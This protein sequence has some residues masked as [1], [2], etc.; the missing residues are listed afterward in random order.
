M[1]FIPNG[2][3]IPDELLMARDAGN[4]LFF[5]GAGVSRAEAKLPDFNT[6]AQMVMDRLGATKSSPARQVFAATE[7][8][9]EEIRNSNAGGLVAAD[10]L[11][12]L[13][14][15][16]FDA[17]DVRQAVAQSL[18][19]ATG[20]SLAPHRTLLELS[21]GGTGTPRLVTTNFDLLFEQCDAELPNFSPPNL[22]DPR[23]DQDFKGIIHLHGRVTDAYDAALNDELVLSSADFGYA[24]LSEGWATRYINLLLQRYQIVFVGYSADDPPVQYLLE[25][26]NRFGDFPRNPMYA[27]HQGDEQ[28]AGAQWSHKGVEP[29]AFDPNAGFSALWDTLDQWAVR[30]RDVDAWH[31]ALIEKALNGPASMQPHERGMVAHLA[32]TTDGAKRLAVSPKPIP[33]QWLFVF[34]R[35]ARFH[36]THKGDRIS[37]D[38][39]GASPHD[40]LRLDSDG[41]LPFPDPR[42]RIRR[43]TLSEDA[44]DAFALCA[45]DVATAELASIGNWYSAHPPSLPRRLEHISNW[46]LQVSHEPAALVWAAG[47]HT[48][49]PIVRQS[50]KNRLRFNAN[51]YSSS[52]RK[53]WQLV[54]SG[55]E[56]DRSDPDHEKYTIEGI[57]AISGW[58]TGLVEEAIRL[59]RPRLS[60]R[61]AYNVAAFESDPSAE[62]VSADFEYVQPHQPIEFDASVRAYA[63]TLLRHEIDRAVRGE[64]DLYPEYHI[65]I[66]TLLDNDGEPGNERASGIDGI[67]ATYAKMLFTLAEEDATAA[68]NELSH[69]KM[70]G[71]REIST[72]MMIV[73]VASASLTSPEESA[74]VIEAL[75][76]EVFWE[77]SNER[78]LLIAIKKRWRD[79]SQLAKEKLED[80]LLFGNIPY[81][82]EWT[83]REAALARARLN[84]V[85]WFSANGID[86]GY[87]YHDEMAILR[88]LLPDWTEESA[89]LT[90]QPRV[91]VF[92]VTRDTDD[93]PLASLPLDKIVERA[94]EIRAE[95]YRSLDR[96]NEPFMG[97]VTAKP[98]RAAKALVIALRKGLFL[99]WAWNDLLSFGGH[100]TDRFLRV[101]ALRVAR[102]RTSQL[103]E[104]IHPA[105]HWLRT[106]TARLH[107]LHP[108]VYVELWDAAC[109]ALTPALPGNSEFRAKRWV[110][111]SL[112]SAAGRLCESVQAAYGLGAEP[113]ASSVSENVKRRVDRLL[114]LSAPHRQY[115]IVMIA[116]QFDRAMQLDVV[117]ATTNLLPLSQGEGIDADA[118]WQGYL[119]RTT[120]LSPTSFSLFKPALL[121]FAKRPRFDKGAQSVVTATL[122]DRWLHRESSPETETLAD[123]ELRELLIVAGDNFRLDLL[124]CF[125]RWAKDASGRYDDQVLL[126]IENVWP[127]QKVVKTA[128]MTEGLVA[129]AFALPSRFSDVIQL[130]KPKLV[131]VSKGLSV[132]GLGLVDKRI[133]TEHSSALIELLWQV[134]PPSTSSWTHGIEELIDQ[135]KALAATSGNAKLLEL[136][137][138]AKYRA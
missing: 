93:S 134:L 74:N 129:L 19:P 80:R 9:Q 73:S 119:W 111:D 69:W 35:R 2:P 132:V 95:Q 51:N 118:F 100:L 102:L 40:A 75:T 99:S 137:R 33:A 6:L 126:F 91:G 71:L 32:S 127:L 78:D 107:A 97:L 84:R 21:K 67:L 7:R 5:C 47:E 58:T 13:L 45:E 120:A 57:A 60:I 48:M 3:S 38:D 109:A 113:R 53:G 83:D 29:I 43:I 135:L 70:Q 68:Q 1:R 98:S 10:R 46:F 124:R 61:P 34:D 133:V 122:L 65:S 30:A 116:R 42:D 18:R 96:I 114:T 14:E 17:V 90:G 112:N 105:T 87:R 16:E 110:T 82:E 27:F 12:S 31:D 54:L 130:L 88:Q 11:F 85:H 28:Q 76:D 108:D 117:W 41:P 15:R 128:S 25:A 104:V 36:G 101:L 63:I 79:W 23:R 131:S 64:R 77:D 136:H 89:F 26:L 37:F 121:A 62:L 106:H 59:Y 22:P 103:A 8:L 86:I 123:A 24:Y 138:K 94:Q 39:D 72:R 49:H 81:G 115:A 4:V 66:D 125:T 56:Q 92:S 50:L 44:W 55:L 52:V 20:H